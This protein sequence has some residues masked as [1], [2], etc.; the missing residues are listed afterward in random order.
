MGLDHVVNTTNSV[1]SLHH[2]LNE[3]HLRV[4]DLGTVTSLAEVLVTSLIPERPIV[5]HLLKRHQSAQDYRPQDVVCPPEPTGALQSE[6]AAMPPVTSAAT[7][8]VTPTATP[9]MTPAATPPVTAQ[10]R[11]KGLPV[12]RKRGRTSGLGKCK[13][14][15]GPVLYSKNL[16]HIN[17]NYPVA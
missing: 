16:H 14:L 4:Q 9:P 15:R 5:N 6:A 12:R 7:P 1:E 17:K 2:S 8:P 13:E 3:F 10:I 11:R